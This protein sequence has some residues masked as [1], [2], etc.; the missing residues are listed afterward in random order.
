MLE[1]AEASA[2]VL[3]DSLPHGPFPPGLVII[4]R[5]RLQPATKADLLPNTRTPPPTI[6][7][8]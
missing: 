1:D 2:I 8:S 7:P 5:K 4:P 6:Q 3:D